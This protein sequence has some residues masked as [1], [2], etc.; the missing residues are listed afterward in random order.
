M[1]AAP[2]PIA[3]RR[4]TASTSVSRAGTSGFPARSTR[5]NTTPCPAAA[6]K[7]VASVVAPVCNPVPRSAVRR[8]TDRLVFAGGRRRL[9]G[10]GLGVDEP[11]ELVDD[12]GEA[13]HGDLRAQELAM[14][15]R[16][17]PEH[18]GTRGDIGDRARLDQQSRAMSY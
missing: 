9:D 4:S 5:R 10:G 8:D 13:V 3:V 1:V 11:L 7:N 15:A 16:G 17:V 12:F 2:C 14:R 6:G 18:R